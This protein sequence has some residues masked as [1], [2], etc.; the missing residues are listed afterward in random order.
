V[1]ALR[2][3]AEPV[4][5]RWPGGVWQDGEP[6]LSDRAQLQAAGVAPEWAYSAPPPDH[7][8]ELAVEVERML[9]RWQREAIEATNRDMAGALHYCA[10]SLL[11]A[12]TRY[13]ER[14][15]G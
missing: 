11:P 12:L 10:H 15:N 2:A 1:A 7:A 13:K 14:T 4:A 5:W 6:S 9:R 8:E 3:Q